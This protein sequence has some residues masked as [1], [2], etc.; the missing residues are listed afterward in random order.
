MISKAEIKPILLRFLAHYPESG[1]NDSTL[2][3]IAEDWE[4]DLSIHNVTAQ[5]FSSAIK[6]CRRECSFFPK[7][8]DVLKAAKTVDNFRNRK[9]IY[10][11]EQTQMTEEE[12]QRNKKRV[13]ALINSIGTDKTESEILCEISVIQ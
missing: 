13:R 3:T 9:Q 12:C 8:S 7:I 4:E 10:L 6:V 1:H 2:E 11:P 5:T